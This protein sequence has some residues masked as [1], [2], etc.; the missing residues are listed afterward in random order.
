[1]KKLMS[2]TQ[3]KDEKEGTHRVR[4][5]N[6]GVN[7]QLQNIQALYSQKN[8][9]ELINKFF[10]LHQEYRHAD[11][12]PLVVS[13]FEHLKDKYKDYKSPLNDTINNSNSNGLGLLGNDY[14]SIIQNNRN[15]NNMEEENEDEEENEEKEKEKKLER[16]KEMIKLQKLER[17]HSI[18][19]PPHNFKIMKA[20]LENLA[21][22]NYPVEDTVKFLK[23]MKVP[24]SIQYFIHILDSPFTKRI[25]WADKVIR[26]YMKNPQ[27]ELVFGSVHHSNVISSLILSNK[28]EEAIR[29]L[30]SVDHRLLSKEMF[31]NAVH[32]HLELSE[33]DK[34]RQLLYDRKDLQKTPEYLN[35]S[36]ELALALG[37]VQMAAQFL[38]IKAKEKQLIP[39]ELVQNTVLM[40]G[41]HNLESLLEQLEETFG[42]IGFNNSEFKLLMINA[43]ESHPEKQN[44]YIK[45]LQSN[46]TKSEPVN[47]NIHQ[48]KAEMKLLFQK[49]GQVQCTVT[50]IEHSSY[51]YRTLLHKE[52]VLEYLKD[53]TEWTQQNL[54]NIVS[55]VKGASVS[56]K[57]L[58]KP[59]P[60]PKKQFSKASN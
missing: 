6:P 12:I 10:N 13:S 56:S 57:P 21:F 33:I 29:Q 9:G 39:L 4:T 11:M 27:K 42:D 40:A 14:N 3:F 46:F 2:K 19:T 18:V 30:E 34:A 54:K 41:R 15:N 55:G 49:S 31:Y 47:R 16:I 60:K 37:D 28:K 24:E 35:A 51:R 59:S 32:I 43:F 5:K 26:S 58:P 44:L 17:E 52:N 22:F 53:R 36:I 23:K 7:S 20:V 8:Y 38:F 50:F 1:M 25:L 45:S 48:N